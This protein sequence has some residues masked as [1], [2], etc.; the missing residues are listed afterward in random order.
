MIDDMSGARAGLWMML[1]LTMTVWTQPVP[2]FSLEDINTSSVRY[3]EQVSPRDYRFQ[4][5]AYYFGLA[6]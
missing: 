2:D 3:G 5:S 6:G 4:I 1:G